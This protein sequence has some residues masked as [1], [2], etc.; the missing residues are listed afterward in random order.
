MA[1][2]KERRKSIDIK[3]GVCGEQI[4]AGYHEQQQQEEEEEN[5]EENCWD[6]HSDRERE[7]TEK[8]GNQIKETNNNTTNKNPVVR[9]ET[10]S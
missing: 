8:L 6:R 9:I 2:D 1:R 10:G 3:F 7:T 5:V 4:G